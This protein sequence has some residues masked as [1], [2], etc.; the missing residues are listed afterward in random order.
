M[1]LSLKAEQKV[2]RP[3]GH[4]R[5]TSRIVKVDHSFHSDS[6]FVVG[7]GSPFVRETEQETRYNLKPSAD[8]YN[9]S[10]GIDKNCSLNLEPV[11]AWLHGRHTEE[12]IMRRRWKRQRCA[13]RS[14]W[15]QRPEEGR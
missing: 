4:T 5:Q 10:E 14:R 8:N 9:Q 1:K 3:I 7:S 13:S 6:R 12:S 2:T 11:P 15:L